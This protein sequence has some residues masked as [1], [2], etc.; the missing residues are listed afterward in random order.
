MTRKRR[1][2]LRVLCIGW[3]KTSTGLPGHR[4]VPLGYSAPLIAAEIDAVQDVPGH[5]YTASVRGR[6]PFFRRPLRAA[7]R[8]SCREM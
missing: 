4:L 8:K 5:R 7:R 2:D 3:H 6:M 1:N